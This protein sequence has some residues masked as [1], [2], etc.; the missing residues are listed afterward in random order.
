MVQSLWSA[1][2]RFEF[3]AV[4][5]LLHDDFICDWPQSRERIRGRD[6]FIAINTH[7]P[8]QW[9]IEVTRLVAAGDEVVTE[10]V[11]R[12]QDQA[13][14]AVSF[15]HFRDGKIIS[16]REYWPEPYEAQPWRKQWVESMPHEQEV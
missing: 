10:I 4:A 5:E 13:N 14:P 8:G 6:N 9:R 2:D 15:F 12:H 1:F 3:D 7:Y 11:A 16:I